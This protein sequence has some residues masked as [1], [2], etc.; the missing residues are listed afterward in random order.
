MLDRPRMIWMSGNR[1]R[2]SRMPSSVHCAELAVVLV[3]GGDGEG[4]RVDQQVAIAAGRSGCRRTRPAVSATSSLRSAVLAM[5][6]SSMVSAITAVPN[7]CGQHHAV[8][9]PAASPSSKLIE[10]MIGL[11]PCS[12]SALSST[13][14]LGA[15]DHQR[16]VHR[17]GEPADHLVHLGH[18]VAAD[19]G[20]AD[21]EA[22]GAFADL[23]AAHRD[24]AVPVGFSCS[25]RHFLRAVGVAALAD[26]EIARSPAAT[27]PAG[28][29]WRPTASTPTRARAPA[30]GGSSPRRRSIASSAA[31]CSASRCRS[32][33]RSG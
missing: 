12:F 13:L 15:V 1:S 31:I 16:R 3:A 21:V 32:S 20:G 25:S 23:L 10:L 14:R 18:L 11:P 27:A 6:A 7:C 5:P 19:E 2:I 9:A 24:A 8:A 17:R 28:T 29:G 26:G 4:Q 30:P 33:R 22:V